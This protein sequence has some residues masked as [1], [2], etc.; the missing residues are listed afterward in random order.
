MLKFAKHKQK[1]KTKIMK[2]SI[3]LVAMAFGVSSAFAQDLTSKKGEPIL[4]EAGDW[5]IAV[6]A[7]PFLNYAGNFF[8]KTATNVAPKFDF[9]TDN[10]TVWGK[11]FKDANTAYRAGIRLGMNNEKTNKNVAKLATSTNTVAVSFPSASEVVTSTH[12]DKSTNIGLTVG[13]E[14]RKG[15]TRLQGFYGAELGLSFGKDKHAYTYGNA[16]QVGSATGSLTAIT[17]A[18]ADDFG[19]NPTIAPAI[20]GLNAGGARVTEIKGGSVIGFGVRGFIGAEYFILPKISIGGEFGWGL[21]LT[22]T[23]K[24]KTTYE[25]IGMSSGATTET[26]GT[27]TIEGAKKSTFGIDT[28]TN[29]TVFGGNTGNAGGTIRLAFHF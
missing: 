17:V 6:D 14:K 8:G 27:A 26:V 28:N 24:S 10:M 3:A 29:N 15:K 13:I 19:T 11:Y 1:Q 4:P 20:Q 16:L 7:T 9:A 21:G 25:G 22:M 2:K 18:D 23:G 5:A 12:K